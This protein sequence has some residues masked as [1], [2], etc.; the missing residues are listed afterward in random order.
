MPAAE[1]S[2]PKKI[3]PT[4]RISTEGEFPTLN[5]NWELVVVLSGILEAHDSKDT[6]IRNSDFVGLHYLKTFCV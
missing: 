5:G 1:R 6:P 3:L 4:R 2:I